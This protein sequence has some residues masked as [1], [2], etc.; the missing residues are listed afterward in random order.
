[1]ELAELQKENELL[2]QS[3]EILFKDLQ[4][5]LQLQ[6]TLG[7]ENDFLKAE[8]QKITQKDYL[9]DSLESKR[10]LEITAQRLTT[11]NEALKKENAGLNAKLET[12]RIAFKEKNKAIK[13]LQE[14]N[15]QGSIS[16]TQFVEK[17]LEIFQQQCSPLQKDIIYR[18]AMD[19][20]LSLSES[21]D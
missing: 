11:E 5:S 17:E 14:Q 16:L 4:T 18:M 9:D 7:A 15:A 6:E 12:A 3:N 13:S 10:L 8:L 2:R 21:S 20:A 19:L 1:M